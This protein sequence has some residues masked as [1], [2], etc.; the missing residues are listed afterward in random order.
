[1]QARGEL[2][3]DGLNRVWLSARENEGVELLFSSIENMLWQDNQLHDLL[4]PANAGR[5]RASLYQQGDVREDEPSET[6][7][8]LMKVSLDPVVFQRLCHEQGLEKA[9]LN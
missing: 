7:G 3:K 5:L 9:L 6:G 4:I 2:S 1:M 8:W